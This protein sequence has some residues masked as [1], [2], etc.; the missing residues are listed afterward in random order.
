MVAA[1][2]FGARL[3][4]RDQVLDDRRR[5]VVAVERRIERRRVAARLRMEPV[6]LQD[7]VVER[8]VGV[9]VGGVHLVELVKRRRA[10]RLAAIRGQDRAVLPVGERH[11]PAARQDQRRM[12][13][14]G[15]RE[16]GIRVVR[17]G[18][19]T[20]RQR[21][22]PF[23]FVVEDMFLLAVEV[24]EHE[25]VNV[26]R[27]A[28]HHPAL[29]RV[30]RNGEQFRFEPGCG[31]RRL[32]EQ[33][34][35]FLPP[36]VR[37]VVALILVVA[38][39]REVPDF[40]FELPDVVAEL[41]RSEQGVAALRQRALERAEFADFLIQLTVGGLPRVPVRIDPGEIPLVLIGNLVAVAGRGR[42]GSLGRG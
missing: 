29:H 31:L 15:G 4:L 28:V 8:R 30:E 7:A 38:E 3:G 23:A 26:Q 35:D 19:E 39:R 42:G 21:Q 36:G 33:D 37:L 17:S 14:V 25:P 22:Q 41:Q 9:D 10:I 18:R 13:R 16:R 32:R 12:L 40:V 1:Q 24:F 34:L 27:R 11:F 6:A 5:D 2:R 20:A